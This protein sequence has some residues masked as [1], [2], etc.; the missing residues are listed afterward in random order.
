MTR[1]F[2][3]DRL[4][5]RLACA[6]LA[7]GFALVPASAGHAQFGGRSG[8][9]TMFTPDFLPRDLPVFVDSL[10][11]EEW[12]RPIL[13]ALLEDYDTNFKT[14]ADGVRSAMAGFKDSAAGASPERVVAMVSQPLVA[15]TSEK[16]KLRAEFL[17]N[18]RTQLSEAQV[19][20]WPR[21][22]RALR[23]DKSLA[24]GELS[25]ESLNLLLLAREL[26]AE[27]MPDA[28]S[29]ALE[30][31]ELDLD[32]ALAA[33]DEALDAVIPQL[34][35]AM[36]A[37]DF[38]AGAQAQE[39]IMQK[40]VAL[41]AVQDAAVAAVRDA[42][43]GDL[44]A[45]FETRAL[46]K[47]FPQVFRPNP[48]VPLLEGALALPDVTA[49]QKGQIESLRSQ[50]DAEWGALQRKTCDAYR[51]SEPG[52]PRRRAQAAQAKAAGSSVKFTEAPEIEAVKKERE[53]LFKR[54]QAALTA[55]L[56][57]AQTDALPGLS[58]EPAAFHKVPQTREGG[59][60]GAPDGGAEPTDAAA[61]AGGKKPQAAPAVPTSGDKVLTPRQPA[62]PTFTPSGSGGPSKPKQ[63]E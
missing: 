51:S 31:Y 3:L 2:R 53:E 34:L 9:A 61:P 28:A 8:M 57:P 50:F 15:W 18:V 56:S 13:E 44:G 24:N 14:A 4:R 11:L 45:R 49:E 22:E 40:R 25:G 30:Q 47:A 39:Q 5:S 35:Q 17:D 37:S 32:A 42:L 55:I 27:A 46:Q 10:Q 16:K 23:R 52:E 21:L 38:N 60:V 20:L 36:S 43:G 29:A 12:Q 54:Y 48:I 26:N 33:R 58:N 62:S 19:E 6:A 59:P 63:A 41:R 1:P 7:A